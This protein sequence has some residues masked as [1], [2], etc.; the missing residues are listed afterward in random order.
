MGKQAIREQSLTMTI[1]Q[2]AVVLG[3]SDYLARRLVKDGTIP[4][5]RLGQATR[6]PKNTINKILEERN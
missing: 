6:I 2:A 4:C 3:I 1:S 5:I